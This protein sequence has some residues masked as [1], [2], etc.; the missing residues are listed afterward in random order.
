M[1]YLSRELEIRAA[2]VQYTQAKIL[3]LDTEVADFRTKKPRLSLIQILADA[4]DRRGD[5]VTILDVL[6]YP[7]LVSE[8]RDKVMLNPEINK[9]FHNAQYDLKFLGKKQM[10]EEVKTITIVISI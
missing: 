1:P 2:I 5:Q 7:D 4:T 6:V 3:W 10:E 9:V 8:F